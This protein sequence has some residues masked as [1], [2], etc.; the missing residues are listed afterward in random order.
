M[1]EDFIPP[2]FLYFLTPTLVNIRYENLRAKRRRLLLYKNTKHDYAAG[3]RKE[4]VDKNIT[5]AETNKR[6][7]LGVRLD[8]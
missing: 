2:I 1:T 4:K 7:V 5:T 3:E 6:M 8:F